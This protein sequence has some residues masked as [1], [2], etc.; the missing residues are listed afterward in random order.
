MDDEIPILGPLRST[1]ERGSYDLQGSLFLSLP[2]R[3]MMND[4][5]ANMGDYLTKRAGF[6]PDALLRIVGVEVE[7]VV[8]VS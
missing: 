1:P 6:G 5:L 7:T 3:Q 8:D 4:L 2:W